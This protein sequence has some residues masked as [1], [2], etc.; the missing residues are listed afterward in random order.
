MLWKS[1]SISH[2]ATESYTSVVRKVIPE[3]NHSKSKEDLK[4]WF[5]VT[6]YLFGTF[7]TMESYTLTD[8]RHRLGMCTL[9]NKLGSLFSGVKTEGESKCLK[10]PQNSFYGVA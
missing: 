5:C 1:L 8:T 3:G 10:I 4:G 7:N 2:H 9:F 6:E